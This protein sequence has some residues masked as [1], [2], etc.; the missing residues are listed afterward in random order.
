MATRYNNKKLTLNVEG[1]SLTVGDDLW[2]QSRMIP[3][4][5]ANGTEGHSSHNR[6]NLVDGRHI[7]SFGYGISDIQEQSVAFAIEGFHLVVF[8]SFLVEICLR[9]DMQKLKMAMR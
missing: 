2:P 4:H 5:R 9:V 8:A 6:G 7:S 1:E 3:L